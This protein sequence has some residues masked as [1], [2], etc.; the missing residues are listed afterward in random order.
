MIEC[1]KRILMFCFFSFSLL[2]LTACSKKSYFDTYVERLE[3][4]LGEPI[5]N[6]GNLTPGT[7]PRQV[8][9]SQKNSVTSIDL[10]EFLSLAPCE[11]QLIIAQRNSALGK[12][13]L[14]SQKLI[15]E[16]LF[17]N[18]AQECVDQL[19]P[20]YQALKAKI[21]AAILEKKR[22]LP[23]TIARATLG[24]P[25]F[26]EMWSRS[27]GE[28]F[29]DTK[30]I[31]ALNYIRKISENWLNGNYHLEG[32]EL[33]ENLSI[34]RS[35]P[36]ADYMRQTLRT[37]YYLQ[38]LTILIEE[39]YL[40]G[41]FCRDGVIT[42][43]GRTLRNVV[44]AYFTKA[45][46]DEINIASRGSSAFLVEIKKLNRLFSNVLSEEYKDFVAN[47]FLVLNRS[48]ESL[49]EHTASLEPVVFGCTS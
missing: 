49:L 5:K 40:R 34:L 11:L 8:V 41:G 32:L 33:E 43:K 27:V 24:G 15:N 36:L 28:S 12:V 6:P 35:A 20:S 46:S 39:E 22:N 16:L 30:G 10:L 2:N 38:K 31:L 29:F 13:A 9:A 48:K 37:N 45:S 4:V 14:G 1:S 19:G 47:Q 26:R 17:L 23:T 18:L 42:D 44:E 25:E 7:F 3:R 21:R